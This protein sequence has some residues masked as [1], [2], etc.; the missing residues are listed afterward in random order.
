MLHKNEIIARFLICLVLFILT[1]SEV[2][3]GWTATICGVIGTV[4]L[5]TALLGYSPLMEA[6][7]VPQRERQPHAPRLAH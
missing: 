5:A 6:R 7:I 1:G 4:E 2:I 3:T